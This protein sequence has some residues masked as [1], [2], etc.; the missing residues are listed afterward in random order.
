MREKEGE[1]DRDRERERKK[2]R[3]GE[4]RVDLTNNFQSNAV[5]TLHLYR[6]RL[7]A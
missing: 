7:T 1:R 2:V 4:D 5:F 3:D 6:T